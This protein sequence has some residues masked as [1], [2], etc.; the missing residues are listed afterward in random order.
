MKIGWLADPGNADGTL[1]GAELTQREFRQAKPKGVSTVTVKPDQLEKLR[2]VD[3][4]CVFNSVHYPEQTVSAL[5][6]KRVV[7]YFNDVAPHGDPRLTRWLIAN[8]DC[9]FT[10]PLHLERFPWING[11][12][13]STHLIPPPVQLDRFREAFK[14]HSQRAG[15]V[16]L[17]PWMNPG[18]APHRAAEWAAQQGVQIDFYGGGPFAPPG[19]QP[20]AYEQ[21]PGTLARYEWFVHLPAVLEPFGRTVVEAWAAGCKPVVNGL[22]G[23]AYWLERDRDRLETAANDF[24]EVVTDG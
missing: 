14:R 18:K 11:H 5:A 12:K 7:R 15:A 1:G 17:G 23:A 8:A 3:V 2:D 6:G 13:P 10:S 9:V 21:V 20:L 19:S 16:A 22:V 4:V 24:W